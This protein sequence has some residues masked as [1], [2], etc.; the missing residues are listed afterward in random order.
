MFVRES[1][2]KRKIR[3]ACLL[4]FSKIENNNCVI[5][6]KNG[7]ALFLDNVARHFQKGG[8]STVTFFDIGA[9]IGDYT[10]IL[11]AMSDRFGL[12]PRIFSFEPT[13]KSY[14][15]LCSRFG[16]KNQVKIINVAASDSEGET[17][18][19]FDEAGSKLASLYPRNL[20]MYGIDMKLN[21]SIKTMRLDG[22]IIQDGIDHIHLI[23][24]DVEGHELSVLSGLGEYLRPDFIDFIQFE[25]GGANLD[26]H[27]SL[28]DL[29]SVFEKAD[30]K[31]AKVMPTGLEIR[32]YMPYM[33]NFQ[34]ANYV[35]ISSQILSG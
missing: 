31:V 8:Q 11:L 5:F 19:Y 27:S 13:D 16:T 1:T 34:Y 21:E 6:E 10:D 17:T 15:S 28:M 7:E 25:Y 26:S 4:V 30:F 3:S 14:H 12:S 18:I 29:Y 32:A 35:A 24:M 2:I 22:L 9:N 20:D 33:E 23:K